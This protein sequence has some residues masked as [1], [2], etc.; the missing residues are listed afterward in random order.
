[1]PSIRGY[2]I[3][4]STEPPSFVNGLVTGYAK[5]LMVAWIV[6]ELITIDMMYQNGRHDSGEM[7]G[8]HPIIFKLWPIY[9]GN[10]PLQTSF[11]QG[12]S[13][14]FR[15]PY[16]SPNRTV[17]KLPAWFLIPGLIIPPNLFLDI[18]FTL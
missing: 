7:F 10:K 5:T 3:V 15:G 17:Y 11:T 1:M 2:Y 13:R 9:Y 18:R 14:E 4:S 16:P 6:I 8:R 12:I